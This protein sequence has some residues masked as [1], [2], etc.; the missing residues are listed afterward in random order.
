MI[1]LT[2]EKIRRDKVGNLNLPKPTN[3][4]TVGSQQCHCYL[5]ALKLSY[6]RKHLLKAVYCVKV[7]IYLTS[8]LH[9]IPSRIVD[10]AIQFFSLDRQTD[11]LFTRT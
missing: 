9:L 7:E 6:V 1:F 3:Q 8:K 11:R 5:N 4:Q 2:K 10:I